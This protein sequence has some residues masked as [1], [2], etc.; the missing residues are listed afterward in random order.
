MDAILRDGPPRAFDVGHLPGAGGVG[1]PRPDHP[2]TPAIPSACETGFRMP[3]GSS[4]PG[5]CHV[6]MSGDPELVARTIAEFAGRVRE[7]AVVGS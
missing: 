6:S 5:L 7:P 4:L 3:S 1:D 2:V